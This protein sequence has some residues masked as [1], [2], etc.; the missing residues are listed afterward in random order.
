MNSP[1]GFVVMRS[2]AKTTHIARAARRRLQMT[3][4]WP[5]SGR[6]DNRLRKDRN[7]RD[8]AGIRAVLR[9][10]PLP[11][12]YPPMP[13]PLSNP[14]NGG[15]R[16]DLKSTKKANPPPSRSRGREPC[17]AASTSASVGC[18]E[19]IAR[20]P[21]RLL[22]HKRGRVSRFAVPEHE[23]KAVD[24]GDRNSRKQATAGPSGDRGVGSAVSAMAFGSAPAP[25]IARASFGRASIY[26]DRP[27]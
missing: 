14:P 1:F 20:L 15:R 8:A 17:R 7:P 27:L 16:S 21:V 25:L 18:D 19:H 13:T 24:G 2:A 11:R 23:Q 5:P 9:L 4:F 6:F 22:G 12:D 10:P 26:I 3:L